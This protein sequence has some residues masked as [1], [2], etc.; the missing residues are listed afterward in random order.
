MSAYFDTGAIMPLYVAEVFSARLNAYLEVH[1]EPIPFSGFHRLEL[2][3]AL[4]LRVFRG[5]LTLADHLQTLDVIEAH[6]G[7]GRLKFRPVNWVAAL[8]AARE[9]SR[10][11]TIPTGCR[12]LDLIHIAIALQW[13]CLEFVSADDRQLKAAKLAGLATVDLRTLAAGARPRKPGRVRERRGAYRTKKRLA[14]V[15]VVTS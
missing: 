15:H 11:V 3:N 4:H 12:T 8:A 10:R 14:R 9:L 7:A 1:A 2:E 5:E 13:G 6:I